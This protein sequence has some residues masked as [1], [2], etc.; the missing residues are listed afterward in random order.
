MSR[1]QQADEEGPNSPN[2]PFH[3]SQTFASSYM[4]SN[5]AE[6]S[7]LQPL[8]MQFSVILQVRDTVILSILLNEKSTARAPDLI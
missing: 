8:V 4:K 3:T 2:H 1:G 5:I 7:L 6:K